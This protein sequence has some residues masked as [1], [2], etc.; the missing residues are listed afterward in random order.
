VIAAA[1]AA[2]ITG[3]YLIGAGKG[4]GRV[5]AGPRYQISSLDLN[6]ARWTTVPAGQYRLWQA[7]F[8]R[9]DSFFMLFGTL[10]VLFTGY[11]L[12]AHR[13]ARRDTTWGDSRR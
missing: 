3:S 6:N 4:S 2:V 11:L 7:E 1:S 10:L 8:V 12:L 5:L 13:H 9:G